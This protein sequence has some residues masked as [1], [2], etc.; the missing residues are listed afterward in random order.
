MD[1]GV[2]IKT[3]VFDPKT[4][5]S[6]AE[7]VM[8]RNLNRRHLNASQRAAAATEVIPLLEEEAK[9][10]KAAT[11]FKPAEPAPATTP[12]SKGSGSGRGKKEKP[13]INSL[14][15]AIDAATKPEPPTVGEP[16]KGRVADEVAVKFGVSATM[17]KLAKKLKTDEP[18]LFKK[19]IDGSMTVNEA[20][21]LY[22][23][24]KAAKK[25]TTLSDKQKAERT[26]AL[27]N[28]ER[29]YGADSEIFIAAKK[30]K[31][32]KDHADLVKFSEMNKPDGTP[33][34]PL[35]IKGWKVAKAEK[36][37]AGT[38][39]GK[40]EIDDLL[41]MAAA[42]G[43]GENKTFVLKLTGWKITAERA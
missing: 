10:R 36:F 20:M 29:R 40:D 27:G 26:I 33:L 25:D 21:K 13:G 43:K 41:N 11:Q 8:D 32:L 39:D 2:P 4:E 9:A 16:K 15:P 42:K 31:L 28:I 6:P 38:L 23:Q 19:V 5:G 17:V 3:R 12:P 24:R 7:F 37:V 34:I 18:D 30:K 14:A 22:D 1:A 35:L